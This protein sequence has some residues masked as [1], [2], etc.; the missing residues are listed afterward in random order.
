MSNFLDD[1]ENDMI[2]SL[3]RIPKGG[4]K[5]IL[6]YKIIIAQKHKINLTIDVS[7]KEKGIFQKLNSKKMN[8][9]SKV[10]GIYFDNAI[11]AASES[12]KKR[13]TVEIY[14][15]KD[16]IQ[17]VISNTFKKGSILENNG[18]KG[19]SSK[20][21]GR[22]NGLYFASKIIRN[23]QWLQEKHEIIDRYYVETI[24]ITK[25]TSK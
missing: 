3:R 2:H 21:P 22:G 11:E 1:I 4:L 8:E 12:R 25:N 7:V 15:L 20:G 23:N 10:T 5:G 19:V 24:S 17:I 6:Y 13:I 18:N 9:L 16:K 14:E